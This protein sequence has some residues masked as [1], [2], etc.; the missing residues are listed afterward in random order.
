MSLVTTGVESSNK[1]SY[2]QNIEST[3]KQVIVFCHLQI[4]ADL[5]QL[6]V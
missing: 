3:M 6:L 5:F 4:L 1:V 2:S